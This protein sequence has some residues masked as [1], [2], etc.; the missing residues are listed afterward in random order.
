[1]YVILKVVHVMAVVVFLGNIIVGMFWKLIADGTKN[2]SIMRHTIAG[3]IRS[4]RIFTIPAVIVLLLAGIATAIVGHIPF[5]STGWLLWS[6]ILFI[7]SGLAFGRVARLQ[8]QLLKVLQRGGDSFD[9]QLYEGL[10]RRWDLWG[11]LAT[12]TPLAA[13]V[14]MIAKPALPAFHG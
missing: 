3:I 6:I 10:S 11:I 13:L 4:D 14:L 2:A 1:M 7:I 12:V 5:L 8:A 9:R